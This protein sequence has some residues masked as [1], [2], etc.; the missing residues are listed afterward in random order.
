MALA[1][2][3]NL[4]VA[5]LVDPVPERRAALGKYFPQAVRVE[6]LNEFNA[7]GIDF[8]VVASPQKY[9]A[10]QTMALFGRGI[11]VLCEKPLASS[12][13]EAQAM[14]E[15]SRQTGRL[16]AAGLVRRFFPTTELVRELVQGQALG[17]PIRFHWS[18]GGVFD[19]PAATPSFFRR[20]S[21]QGG[22]LAD[23]GAHV[24][25]LLLH[26]FGSVADFDYHDDN[27]GGLEAN[28]DLRLNFE[29]GVTGRIRLSRDTQIP[30][31]VSIDFEQGTLWFRGGA[32]DDVTFHFKHSSL[33]LKANL[34]NLI[35]TQRGA[36]SPAGAPA[37]TNE[38]CFMEQIRNVSR[39]VRGE[40]N[41]V[42]SGDMALPSMALIE[43]CYELKQLM[44]MPWLGADE[45]I[46][47]KGRFG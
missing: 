6:S 11:H 13:K 20:E 1:E 37:R 28:A 33:A 8:A 17:R 24:I 26:W 9:H 38:Q 42:V 16:L 2:I 45:L 15:A 30:N 25:D 23:I 46:R 40:E 41:L 19:W 29:C 36:G 21:S 27:M 7:D 43:R 44:E 34:H 18:E 22:V 14:V 39:A 31:G 47:V 12:M 4:S 5:L 3:E 10:E 35:N 32:T